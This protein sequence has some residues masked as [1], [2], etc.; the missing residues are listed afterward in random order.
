MGFRKAEPE[1][2][3]LKRE[4]R[5]LWIRPQLNPCRNDY[6]PELR[7]S[8]RADAGEARLK[9]RF[10]KRSKTSRVSILSTIPFAPHRACEKQAWSW[11]VSR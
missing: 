3:I 5:V 10:G 1:W 11:W 8:L 9:I 4:L 2:T 7:S 6:S